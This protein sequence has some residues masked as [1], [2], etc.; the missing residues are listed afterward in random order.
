MAKQSG[1]HSEFFGSR[2]QEQEK[3]FDKH[4]TTEVEYSKFGSL[5][6]GI[7]N[8]IAELRDITMGRFKEGENKGEWYFMAAGAVLHPK[9]FTDK[10]KQIHKTEGKRTQIGPEALCDTPKALG[11]RK[12]YDDHMGFFMNT[13]KRLGL[14][15][16][17][18]D[19]KTIGP[20]MDALVASKVQFKFRTWQGKPSEEFPNPKVNHDWLEATKYVPGDN[21]QE[22]GNQDDTKDI[23]IPDEPKPQ[24]VQGSGSGS[25]SA[26]DGGTSTEDNK[27]DEF[28]DLDSLVELAGKEGDH[29]VDAQ[30]RLTDMALKEGIT[31][32]IIDKTEH[33]GEVAELIRGMKDDDS[34]NQDSGKEAQPEEWIPSKGETVKYHELDKKKGTPKVKGIDAEVL[35]VNTEKKTANVKNLVDNSTVKGVPFS[36]LKS[37]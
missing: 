24:P 34:S 5:P 15:T 21:D 22:D 16:K 11:E 6:P 25:G 23:T 10:E 30:N 18:L 29:K 28:G 17:N 7:E 1:G 3:I 36:Q 12:T 2:N 37:N 35:A 19:N 4:R 32:E 26:T 33:W 9:T 13:L 31:Q 27:F 8:G 14:E 20:A